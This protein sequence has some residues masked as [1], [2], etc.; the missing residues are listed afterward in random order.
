M[1]ADAEDRRAS[2]RGRDAGLGGADR[3]YLLQACF[4]TGARRA[5]PP[6]QCG[7]RCLDPAGCGPA[8]PGGAVPRPASES[9]QTAGPAETR[10]PVNH[11]QRNPRRPRRRSATRAVAPGPRRFLSIRDLSYQRHET[12]L[13]PSARRPAEVREPGNAGLRPHRGLKQRSSGR[14]ICRWYDSCRGHERA[15]RKSGEPGKRRFTPGI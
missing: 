8:K 10:P 12:L 13:V 14:R 15:R 5:S 11:P 6:G 7:R 1:G 3:R 9:L 4:A 2:S